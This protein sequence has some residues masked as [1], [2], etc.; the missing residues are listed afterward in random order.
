M[1]NS[2]LSVLKLR[3]CSID[4]NNTL[5]IARGLRRMT[6]LTTID[7]GFNEFSATGM[8]MLGKYHLATCFD[9]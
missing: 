3:D 8:E 5:Q 9:S 2:V 7:L 6:T 1:G 4:A